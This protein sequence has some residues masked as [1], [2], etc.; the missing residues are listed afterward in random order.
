MARVIGTIEGLPAA[1]D[2]KGRRQR[3]RLFCSRP[4]K[5]FSPSRQGALHFILTSPSAWALAN[6]PV[7][8]ASKFA[9]FAKAAL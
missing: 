4:W 9:L 2:K 8:S 5:A 7:E 6:G 1:V 3:W